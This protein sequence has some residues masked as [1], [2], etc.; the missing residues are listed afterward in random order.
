MLIS[1]EACQI[2]PKF[3]LIYLFIFFFLDTKQAKS[4]SNFKMLI[5]FPENFKIYQE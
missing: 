4:P 5:Y 2:F 3:I 1:W